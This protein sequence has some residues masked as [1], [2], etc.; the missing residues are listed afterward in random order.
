MKFFT[1]SMMLGLMLL[2][3]SGC[4]FPSERRTE[5]QVPPH[6]YITVVQSGVDLYLKK[7]GVLP[8]KNS[9][10]NTPIYE[11]YQIDFKRMRNQGALSIVPPN[12]F[13]N[14]GTNLYVLVNVETEPTVK[15]LDL[16]IYQQIGDIQKHI[17]QF[18]AKNN[19]N[20]PLGEQ[21]SEYFYRL[22][23]KQ[24][25]M[26]EPEIRSPYT[27]GQTLPVLIHE[28]GTAV[29]DYAPEIMKLM[30]DQV[31]KAVDS[32]Q[33]LREILVSNSYFV[34]IHSFPYY[35]VDDKPVVH[36]Q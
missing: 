4:L 19:G 7:T 8:I 31:G 15:L 28:S 11:K 32:H 16:L 33:D 25:S 3:L 10:M 24:M 27:R 9:E 18:R 26:R 22:D 36:E 6:E 12:A 30:Q 21:V 35:W 5:N 23:F 20:L 13:E 29:I 14:G 34:P 2:L 1:F 17:N